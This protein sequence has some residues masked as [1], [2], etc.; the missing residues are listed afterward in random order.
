[1]QLTTELANAL[2]EDNVKVITNRLDF[3]GRV[4]DP[5]I[6]VGHLNVSASLLLDSTCV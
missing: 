3:D 1:M 4:D 5:D 2:M 6:V